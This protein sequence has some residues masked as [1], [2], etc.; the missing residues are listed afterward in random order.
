MIDRQARNKLAQEI[1]HFVECFTD[2]FQ[3]DDAVWNI[4]TK[5]RGVTAIYDDIWLAYDDLTR[6]KM[7]GAYTL[8]KEQMVVV[9]RAIVF[10][11]S[12]YEYSWQS[13][14]IYYRVVRPLL[15]IMSFGV[16]TKRLDQHFI[17][18]GDKEVW[19]FF[20]VEDYRSALQ[21]PRYLN[22]AHHRI[23]SL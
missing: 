20:K 21:E 10:L 2:N 9:K 5:D 19:P 17:G 12:D 18:N 15:W 13:W 1:R 14:P 6:H 4:K 23:S 22:G 7:D 11:K 16:V 8:S 3:F